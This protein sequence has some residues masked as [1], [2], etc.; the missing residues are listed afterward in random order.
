MVI[1]GPDWRPKDGQVVEG[2]RV[3]ALEDPKKKR[4]MSKK[5]SRWLLW[6]FGH[7]HTERIKEDGTPEKSTLE[8]E[9]TKDS[10]TSQ[11]SKG[12]EVT[13]KTTDLY[14]PRPSRGLIDKL[15]RA[16]VET[17]RFRS[18][19]PTKNI[20]EQ[21]NLKIHGVCQLA[22]GY[23]LAYVPE[24]VKIYSHIK[25]HR[26]LSISRLLGMN[27]TPDIKLASTHDVPRILFSL[28]QTVSGGYSLYKA[29]GS[30][31]ERY[32]FAAYGLTVLPYMMVSIINLVG[33]LLTSEYE[34]IYMVHS[35]IMD[36][37]K[38]RGGLC[39]GVV[40]T[41]ERPEHQTYIFIEGEQETLLEGRKMQF[42]N[43]GGEVSCKDLTE[44]ATN[45]ELHVSDRNHI[46]P[47]E[48][49][50]L[51]QKWG[52]KRRE[53]KEKRDSQA[54]PTPI[55]VLRVPSHGSFTRLSQRWS[56][57]CLNS[58]TLA[59][60]ILALGVP[61]IVIAILSGWQNRES[62]P[63]HRTFVLNWLI[64]GQLQGWAVSYVEAATGRRKVMSGLIII[65]VSYGSY[66]I[67]GL[68]AVV[69]EM[70]KFGTC[71]ALS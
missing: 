70:I 56:Q 18:T 68:V 66:S 44:N 37:M 43:L 7:P 55:Q 25:P 24:D 12:D 15:T 17:H 16:L 64:C 11:P 46:D 59:L 40:G 10:P 14:A 57:T 6:P 52:T 22:P 30:Q 41:I 39:D 54:E 1:R 53:R 63:T 21:D 47:T 29:R 58:L 49:V 38:S 13:L 2:C 67:M 32:G 35:A 50:W 9:D 65:F 34:T 62:T 23:A 48:D 4:K 19:P 27:H 71:K 3:E 8:L 20:V 33:S 61:Y 28:I 36:E 5:K 60:L 31:I 42:S 26:T 69:Q 45:P 51:Y